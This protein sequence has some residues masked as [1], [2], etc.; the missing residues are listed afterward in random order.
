MA[1]CIN[2]SNKKEI[3]TLSNYK[4]TTGVQ[5]HT[6][7][8]VR[9]PLILTIEEAMR[10]ARKLNNEFILFISSWEKIEKAS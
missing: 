6:P 3:G 9:I 1:V 7:M 2:Q 5:M 10:K 4:D 8:W